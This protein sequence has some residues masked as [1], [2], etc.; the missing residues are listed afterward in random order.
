MASP[1]HNQVRIG[2]GCFRPTSVFRLQAGRL[3]KDQAC[4]GGAR[5]RL[6]PSRPEPAAS[7]WTSQEKNRGARGRDHWIDS[8]ACVSESSR[9]VVWQ[10][11]HWVGSAIK[12]SVEISLAS[13]EVSSGCPPI[14]LCRL[15]AIVLSKKAR[16]RVQPSVGLNMGLGRDIAFKHYGEC[17]ARQEHERKL[18]TEKAPPAP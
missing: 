12:C 5:E 10:K 9:R 11:L 8:A 1:A 17:V 15:E 13:Q 16:S 7:F 6:E 4:T 3:G 14:W 18:L 2:R